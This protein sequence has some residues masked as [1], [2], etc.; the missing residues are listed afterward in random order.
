MFA[1]AQSSSRR[2]QKQWIGAPGLSQHFS[3]TSVTCPLRFSNTSAPQIGSGSACTSH[4]WRAVPGL[5]GTEEQV[6][7]LLFPCQWPALQLPALP[8]L[9]LAKLRT[10]SGVLAPSICS[11]HIPCVSA[12]WLHVPPVLLHWGTKATSP[13]THRPCGTG[14]WSDLLTMTRGA[15]SMFPAGLHRT[16]KLRVFLRLNLRNSNAIFC[17]L[18]DWRSSASVLCGTH[19]RNTESF[20]TALLTLGPQLLGRAVVSQVA[21]D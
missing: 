7:Y 6:T 17:V 21:E 12:P 3:K 10:Q 20:G 11:G 9:D 8:S 16:R 14:S 13:E 2:A 15:G 19:S 4:K 5:N 18:S 1:R